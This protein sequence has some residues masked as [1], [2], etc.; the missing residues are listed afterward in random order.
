MP[1][2]YKLQEYYQ[3]LTLD[4]KENEM[5]DNFTQELDRLQQKM[6]QNLTQQINDVNRQIYYTSPTYWYSWPVEGEAGQSKKSISNKQYVE[7]VTA[8]VKELD[9]PTLEPIVIKE[10]EFTL[11]SQ[12]LGREAADVL[13]Y[14]ILKE[15]SSKPLAEILAILDIEIIDIDRVRSYQKECTKIA[16]NQKGA[17]VG[18]SGKWETYQLGHKYDEDKYWHKP[19]ENPIPEHVLSKAIQI[20]RE[21]PEAQ[22]YI[23]EFTAIPDPF[24]FVELGSERYCFEVWD[25]PEFEGRLTR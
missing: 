6:N 10:S 22:L 15:E 11:K 18:S 23:E 9:R 4:K 19:Y 20:K 24:M 17:P 2:N 5:P 1:I 12:K 25:E 8:Q 13:G 21:I 16:N 3:L 14:T 7:Q